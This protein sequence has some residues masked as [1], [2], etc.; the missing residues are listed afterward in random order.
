MPALV[1]GSFVVIVVVKLSA[2]SADINHILMT[3]LGCDVYK[4]VLVF[5]YLTYC[6]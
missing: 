6:T 4:Q 3:P 5:E 2:M 1:S